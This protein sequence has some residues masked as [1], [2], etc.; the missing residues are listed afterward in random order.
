M[1]KFTKQTAIYLKE[2]TALTNNMI[3]GHF[4]S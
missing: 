1:L 3:P 4:G 2:A